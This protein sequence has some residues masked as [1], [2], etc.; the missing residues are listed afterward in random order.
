MTRARA[1]RHCTADGL[2]SYEGTLRQRMY[3]E[4]TALRCPRERGLLGHERIANIRWS[5]DGSRVI[6]WTGMR[7]VGPISGLDT[8]KPGEQPAVR[9]AYSDSSGSI[10]AGAEANEELAED[11]ATDLL[12]ETDMPGFDFDP[13]SERLKFGGDDWA[14]HPLTDSAALHY[15]FPSGDR[16]YQRVSAT[17]SASHPLPLGL[18]G[19]LEVAAGTTWD[20]PPVQREFFMGG[21]GTLRGFNRN[22]HRGPTYWRA[23][24]ELATGLAAARLGIFSDLGW[25][26]EREA[27]S[28]DDPLASVGIGL[29]L[30]DGLFRAD[31]AR[32]VRGRT[33]WKVHLLPR[34]IVLAKGLAAVVL[35]GLRRIPFRSQE[36][37]R[38]W[39]S[40]VVLF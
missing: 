39:R 11:M 4:L 37:V 12:D 25:V 30:L 16:S 3:V 7:S 17:L 40:C 15:R 22:G 13:G 29:S 24:G 6:Q 35:T 31:L 26:G 38:R 32:A 1:A 2:E 14:L 34:R 5:F 28:F 23:R 36:S 8:G 19:A 33:G 27:F 21:A 9:I 20:D 18:S 10:R